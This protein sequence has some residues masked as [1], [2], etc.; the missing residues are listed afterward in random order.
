MIIADIA[1]GTEQ[2]FDWRKDAVTSTDTP[3]ILDLCP[4]K[5]EW[6]LWAEKV[7]KIIPV[8]LNGNPNVKRGKENEDFI[9]QFIEEKYDTG[10]LLPLC[11]QSSRF[12]F[13]K[14]SL[15]GYD[16]KAPW[17][18][19]APSLSV[20]EDIKSN[21]ENNAAYKM[22][23]AQ[24]KHEIIATESDV[25]YLIFFNIYTG[26]SLKFDIYVDE[27]DLEAIILKAKDFHYKVQN[28]IEPIKNKNRDIFIPEYG[29]DQISWINLASR[30][31]QIKKELKS[32]ES[33]K[34][35]AQEIEELLVSR[36]G[37]YKLAEFGGI[38]VT[39]FVRKNQVNFRRLINELAPNI[40]EA[41]IEKYRPPISVDNESVR[42]SPCQVGKPGKRSTQEKLEE[43]AQ[44]FG[45]AFF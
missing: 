45:D 11:V 5:T 21:K 27:S 22:Y 38:Q 16:G 34:Q 42:I 10:I 39:R 8:D 17:E 3:V 25:G 20:F 31:G 12:N 15:D 2:W 41:D 24:V 33:L 30:L 4:Y 43:F 26:E 37:D 28:N 18:I 19:K 1:Q 32:Y 13:I 9:R 7:G 40:T 29:D 23:A 35:E 6:R 44:S 36:M 14:S